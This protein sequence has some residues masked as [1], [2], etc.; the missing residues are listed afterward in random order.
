VLEHDKMKPV[1][2]RLP[3]REWPEKTVGHI[4]FDLPNGGSKDALHLMLDD[5]GERDG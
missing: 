3:V 1:A 4:R 2:S 5:D